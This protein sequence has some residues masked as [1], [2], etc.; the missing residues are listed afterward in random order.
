MKWDFS[1]GYVLYE[2]IL[3][4]AGTQN[5][6]RVHLLFHVILVGSVAAAVSYRWLNYTII[7]YNNNYKLLS[8]FDSTNVYLLPP[9]L[10]LWSNGLPL[11]Y[12]RPLTQKISD[13]RQERNIVFSAFL[14]TIC[15]WGL[16]YKEKS[17]KLTWTLLAV[18]I[19]AAVIHVASMALLYNQIISAMKR[20]QIGITCERVAVS[21]CHHFECSEDDATI[22]SFWGAKKPSC[23]ATDDCNNNWK[24]FCWVFHVQVVYVDTKALGNL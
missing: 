9:H 21:N 4:H 24:G 22:N 12:F 18:S 13:I 17:L 7:V 5:K 19:V 11:W 6:L 10:L 8:E 2:F 23:I 15:Y 3:F 16:Q 14:L 1:C 20:K